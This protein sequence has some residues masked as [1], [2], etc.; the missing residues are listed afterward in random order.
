[1][2]FRFAIMGA[3]NIAGKFCDAVKYI[4]G[5]EVVAVASKSMERAE[6]FSAR[7][8]IGKAYDSYEEMLQQEK[9]DCVYIATTPDSHYSLSKLCMKYKAPV[10]CEK[11]M[12]MNSADAREIFEESEKNQVFA[13]EAMWSRFLPANETAKNWIA[14]GRIGEVNCLTSAAG[15]AFDKEINRRNFDPKLGGGAA[16]D[17][18]VYNYELATWFLGHD[19]IHTDIVALWD[20]TGIDNMN[21]ICLKYRDK[22]AVLLSSC[23]SMLEEKLVISGTEGKIVIPHAHF[24]NEAFLYDRGGNILEHYV[25]QM[26]KNGFVYEICEVME[27]IRASK[28]ES[29]VVPHSDTVECAELFDRIYDGR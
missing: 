1:M 25:D 24:A 22:V 13:M 21:H 14:Q 11:A 9:P 19:V 3:G 5:C 8:N 20:E 6:N 7:W 16:F 23:V 15:C 4:S 10:L 17:L 2:K 18:T 27:C 29:K 26:T 12:F 28:I